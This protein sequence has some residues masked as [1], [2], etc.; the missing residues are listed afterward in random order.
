[1]TIVWQTSRIAVYFGTGLFGLFLSSMSP[2][3]M[4]LTE[5]FIVIN[6]KYSFTSWFI[7]YVENIFIHIG[8]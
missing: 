6:G 2:T 5:Q 7:D 3:I 1:M 8:K 4:A